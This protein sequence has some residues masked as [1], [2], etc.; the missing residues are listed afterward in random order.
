[1]DNKVN[2]SDS[3]SGSYGISKNVLYSVSIGDIVTTSPRFKL[4]SKR[5][6]TSKPVR[7]SVNFWAKLAR[8]EPNN[9]ELQLFGLL[10]YLEL[11]YRYTGNAQFILN[12]KAPDFVH[13]EK[14]KIIELFGERWHLPEEEEER[15]MDFATSGYQVVVVWQKEL[16]V[17]NRKKLIEKIRFFESLPEI[18]WEKF[19]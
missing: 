10:T 1:M 19:S 5:R 17:K 4:K 13:N 18:K 6:K 2:R 8:Q 9:A 12:G 16:K 3:S 15:T 7:R 11:L 14:R